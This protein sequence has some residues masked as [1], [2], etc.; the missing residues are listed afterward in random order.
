MRAKMRAKITLGALAILLEVGVACSGS[1]TTVVGPD[2]GGDGRAGATG[3]GGSGGFSLGGSTGGS[4]GGHP[5]GS[6]GGGFGGGFGGGGGDASTDSGDSG[7]QSFACGGLTCFS[8]QEYCSITTIGAGG[9]DGGNGK[10]SCE[11]MPAACSPPDCT[12][13]LANSVCTGFAHCSD[14]NGN[15]T[16]TCAQP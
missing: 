11:T 9:P 10:A 8:P 4:T 6:L 7:G 2:G 12:C 15:F 5:G 3:G 14:S 13:I 16:V 1:D